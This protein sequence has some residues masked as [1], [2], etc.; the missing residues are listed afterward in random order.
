MFL[1]KIYSLNKANT[2]VA[3]LFHHYNHVRANL[4]ASIILRGLY[5]VLNTYKHDN[6]YIKI[7]NRQ[8]T[9]HDH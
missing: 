6:N 3:K 2:G 9:E 1:E 4:L 5:A 7:T 8:Y